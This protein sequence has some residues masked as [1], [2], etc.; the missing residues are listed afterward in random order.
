MNHY[1]KL[2]NC[3]LLSSFQT[4]ISFSDLT[5]TDKHWFSSRELI[6]MNTLQHLPTW[7]NIIKQSFE[8]YKY[9]SHFLLTQRNWIIEYGTWRV[10]Q[11]TVGNDDK[12]WYVCVYCE[13]HVSEDYFACGKFDLQNSRALNCATLPSKPPRP[14]GTCI[15]SLSTHHRASSY[16][17]LQLLFN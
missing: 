9:K 1:L 15:L 17:S 6:T 5:E 3:F 11:K 8:S 16:P 14:S 4:L 12:T 2:W 10:Y 7:L 13:L